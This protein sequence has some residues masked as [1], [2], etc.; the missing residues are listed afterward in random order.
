MVE[1]KG[2]LIVVSHDREFL[3]NVVTSTLA[4]EAGGHLL[5]YAGGYS[6][7][8]KQGKALNEADNPNQNSKQNDKPNDNDT[9]PDNKSAKPEKLSYKLQLELNQLPDKVELLEQ[10]VSDLQAQTQQ[11]DFYGQAFE[12][13][14]PVLNR[15]AAKQNELE[16]TIERW[17]ELEKM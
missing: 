10:Q 16:Q 11:Q 4:F 12:K 8:L 6:D 3:D 1:Y 17:S 7:W 14:Q 2:T 15:L 5:S 13:V 9:K